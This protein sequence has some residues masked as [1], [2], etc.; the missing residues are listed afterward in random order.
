MC[1]HISVP[2]DGLRRAKA[3]L[4]HVEDL[5]HWI[6]ARVMFLHLVEPISLNTRP[7]IETVVLER[8]TREAKDY[9]AA[10][11]GELREKGIQTGTHV[12]RGGVVETILTIAEREGAD[13]IAMAS[14]GRSDLARGFYGSVT[15]GVLQRVNHPLLIVRSSGR[16]RNNL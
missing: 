7:A 2:L 10:L 16:Q 15:A 1:H 9:L 12:A 4:P 11:Q 8:Q 6:D 5:A 13:L 3:L 14:H